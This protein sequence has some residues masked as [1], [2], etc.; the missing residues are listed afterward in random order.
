MPQISK[1]D[2]VIDTALFLFKKN[3]INLTGVNEIAKEAQISKKTL[4]NHFSSK[5]ELVLAALRKDDELG[6]NALMRYAKN[7]SDDPNEKL[8]AIFDFYFLWFSSENFNGCLFTNSA[9]EISE[10]NVAGKHICAEHKLLIEEFV[11][12]L[13]VK[14]NKPNPKQTAEKINLLLEGAIVY[15]YVL[16]KPSAVKEAKEIASMLLNV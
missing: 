3:G 14:S 11:M 6:R 12:E 5:E 16:D 4:Y 9:A 10:E 7:S 2:T 1:R 15:A 13:L 8:L